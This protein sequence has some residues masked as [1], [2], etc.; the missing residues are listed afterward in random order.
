MRGKDNINVAGQQSEQA[1]SVDIIEPSQIVTLAEAIEIMEIDLVEGGIQDNEVVGQKM[2]L[3]EAADPEDFSFFQVSVTQTAFMPQEQIDS[4]NMPESIYHLTKDNFEETADPVAGIGD[5]AF[6]DT[7]GLHLWYRGYYVVI[8]LGN[9][10]DPENIERLK[11]VG[12]KAVD[13]LDRLSD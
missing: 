3:Y 13:N 2:C 9:S 10:D 6:I 1:P 11:A 5:D 12:Q 7:P 4:G 8:G